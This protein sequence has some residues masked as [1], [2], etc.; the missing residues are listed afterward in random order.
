VFLPLVLIFHGQNLFAATW[1]FE[2]VGLAIERDR[3]W[4]P[5]PLQEIA[6]ELF[7][8]TGGE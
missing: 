8:M 4:E 3:W 7:A 6:P 2:V 5:K 1:E